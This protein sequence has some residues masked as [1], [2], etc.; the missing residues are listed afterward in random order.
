MPTYKSAPVTIH[1]TVY[2]SEDE[3]R[4][5]LEAGYASVLSPNDTKIETE[6]QAFMHLASDKIR[7]QCFPTDDPCK[8]REVVIEPSSIC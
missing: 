1:A 4:E 8:V 5:L 7:Q 3:V 2:V 6:Q